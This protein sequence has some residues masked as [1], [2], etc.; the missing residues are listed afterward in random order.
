MTEEDI[1]QLQEE[2]VDT[3]PYTS[4]HSHFVDTDG[5]V[6]VPLG[7]KVQAAPDFGSYDV[8]GFKQFEQY[9]AKNGKKQPKAESV[10]TQ[11][12]LK[13]YAKEIKQAKL[14][15]FRSFLDFTA[16]TFRDKRRHKIDNYVT[17]RWVLTIKVDKDGQFK[18]FK[19]R[20]VCRGLQD[21]QKYDLQTNSPTANRYGFRVASQHAASM[22]WDLLLLDLKT[23]FLQQAS[24][25]PFPLPHHEEPPPDILRAYGDVEPCVAI[26]QKSQEQSFH[27]PPKKAPCSGD[28]VPSPLRSEPCHKS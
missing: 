14:E 21:A 6:F 8:T 28:Q 27:W 12:V 25:G 9:L 1:A 10:I 2:D 11:E 17:G 5:N 20:W 24:R 23:A 3:E 13:K 7:P 18:K 15:E 16:M 22:Y 26:F 4:D 19:A